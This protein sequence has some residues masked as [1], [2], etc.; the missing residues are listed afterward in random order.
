MDDLGRVTPM[1]LTRGSG[2]AVCRLLEWLAGRAVE[3][4]PSLTRR[5]LVY[6][7]PVT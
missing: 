5:P 3:L 4:N 1:S 6:V 7:S 2:W